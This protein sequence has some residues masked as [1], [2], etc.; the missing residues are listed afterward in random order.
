MLG[1]DN[2]SVRV[3]E[4]VYGP[5]S[6]SQLRTFA[7]EGRL[8][9]WS[10]ISPAGSQT[11]RP[12]NEVSAFASLFK[13]DHPHQRRRIQSRSFGRHDPAART[14]ARR[15]TSPTCKD[16][17]EDISPTSSLSNFVLIFDVVSGA[18]SRVEAAIL[19]LGPGFRLSD[20]VWTL[21]S[22]LT[23]VGIRN[24]IAP[25]LNSNESIFVIDATHGRSAW[26]NYAPETQAKLGAAWLNKI[27]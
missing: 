1:A 9:A 21:T 26:K 15:N 14:P 25:Y 7:H 20:N 2:W 8:A 17:N 27:Y 10:L 11:W 3:D 4:K 24:A 16:V 13:N 19:S 12:A 23:V 22:E 6:F 5:Y 18:A